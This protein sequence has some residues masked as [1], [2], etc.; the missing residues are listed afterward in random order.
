MISAA[1]TQFRT[2][3][4]SWA[5][6]LFSVARPKRCPNRLV[7]SSRAVLT[8]FAEV[9]RENSRPEDSVSHSGERCQPRC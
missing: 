3:S 5:I 8:G 6:I 4:T 9:S 2:P 7:Q 1:D